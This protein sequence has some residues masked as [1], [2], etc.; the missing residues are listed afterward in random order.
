MG[1]VS[2]SCFDCVFVSNSLH[3][4]ALTSTDVQTPFLGTPLVPLTKNKTRCGSQDSA[5][6]RRSH[7]YPSPTTVGYPC[8]HDW[9]LSLCPRLEAISVHL[10]F[11]DSRRK[12]FSTLILL[13]GTLLI[14][15]HTRQA[16]SR[17]QN[18]KELAA[19][20]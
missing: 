20:R 16:R 12:P 10:T 19:A 6:P 8:G 18:K 14:R 13:C 9:G 15:H 2:N 11:R 1:V 3:A 4:Q 17:K 7:G 5:A